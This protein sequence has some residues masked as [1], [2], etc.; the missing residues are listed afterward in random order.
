MRKAMN[1]P[2]LRSF[3]DEKASNEKDKRII[4]LCGLAMP[5]RLLSISPIISL[6]AVY[7]AAVYSCLYLLF[8][9]VIEVFQKTYNW[10]I[11]ISG[12]S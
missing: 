6:I 2:D 5:I 7:I 11:Q 4:F 12:L 9:T 8:T 3:Y 1:R 10:S